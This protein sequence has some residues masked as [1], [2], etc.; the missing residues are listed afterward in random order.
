MTIQVSAAPAPKH[1]PKKD[2]KK[3]EKRKWVNPPRE[4][5]P[6]SPGK[7]AFLKRKAEREAKRKEENLEAQR[8]GMLKTQHMS[9]D[10]IRHLKG[11]ELIHLLNESILTAGE[12]KATIDHHG[13]SSCADLVAYKRELERRA[14]KYGWKPV[15]GDKTMTA[16]RD[17]MIDFYNKKEQEAAAKANA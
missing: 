5:R 9:G 2:Q 17:F 11:Q 3:P 10:M 15:E 1:D 13:N 14:R 4:R 12:L 8:I 7:I 16:A 6:M